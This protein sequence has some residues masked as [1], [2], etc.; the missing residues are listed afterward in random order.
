MS[1]TIKIN[2]WSL[3]EDLKDAVKEDLY[4]TFSQDLN[5]SLED[6]FHECINNQI[7][8]MTIYRGDC[9]EI[10]FVMTGYDPFDEYD[11]LGVVPSDWYEAAR[12]ALHYLVGENFD[13]HDIIEELKSDELLLVLQSKR[14]FD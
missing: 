13:V 8:N 2:K 11:N 12:N 10:V 3:T 5:V 4:F 14:K 1:T 9:K 6:K 7:D